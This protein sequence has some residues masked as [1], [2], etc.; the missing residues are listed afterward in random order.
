[1]R[2]WTKGGNACSACPRD[3]GSKIGPLGICL[4]PS[5]CSSWVVEAEDGEEEKSAF[6]NVRARADAL[7]PEYIFRPLNNQARE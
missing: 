6:E 7:L 1:M 3:L 5:L 2:G 4:S